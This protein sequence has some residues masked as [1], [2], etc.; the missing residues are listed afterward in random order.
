[1][2]S[3]LSLALLLVL[4]PRVSAQTFDFYVADEEPGTGK[5]HSGTVTVS[6]SAIS[7][8]VYSWRHQRSVNLS[9]NLSSGV[10]TATWTER[11]R[12]RGK[13]KMVNKST[14]VNIR[15]ESGGLPVAA[16]SRTV[17]IGSW[18]EIGGDG[19]SGVFGGHVP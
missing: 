15:N 10:I 2:F 19:Q 16:Q 13:W 8:S 17:L 5:F 6:G 4:A 7:G 12:V 1:M 14:N 3:L 9:G 18:D 11:Q